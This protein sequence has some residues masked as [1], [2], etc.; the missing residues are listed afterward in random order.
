MRAHDTNV[1]HSEKPLQLVLQA[2]RRLVVGDSALAIGREQVDREFAS[3]TC[4][5]LLHLEHHWV[6][7]AGLVCYK[8]VHITRARGR[9]ARVL[10]EADLILHYTIATDNRA[11]HIYLTGRNVLKMRL[12]RAAITAFRICVP[13]NRFVSDNSIRANIHG[14]VATLHY[15]ILYTSL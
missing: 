5:S 7:I 13:H 2:H 3:D 11:F 10:H 14:K 8:H 15:A 1:T 9:L 12:D 6:V 4:G